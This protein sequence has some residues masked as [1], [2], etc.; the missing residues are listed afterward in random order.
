MLLN[1][2]TVTDTELLIALY[3]TKR[4]YVEY[5]TLF[6][7]ETGIRRVSDKL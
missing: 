4:E 2:K 6:S 7:N 3:D 5:R 1:P